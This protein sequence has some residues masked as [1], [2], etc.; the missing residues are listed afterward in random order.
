VTAEIDRWFAVVLGL[1]ALLHVAVVGYLHQV[2]WPRRPAL[3]EVPDRFIRQMSRA[4][5]PAPP[6]VVPAPVAAHETAAAPHRR[7]VPSA[8]PRPVH[9]SAERHADI[10]DQVRKMG[11]IPL[12]TAASAD[13]HAAVSDLLANGAVDRS[14]DEAMR[15][16]GGVTVASSDGL[17]GLAR[18]GSGTGRVGVPADLRGSG[19]IAEAGPND[20][21]AERDVVSHLKL[22]PPAVEGGHADLASITREI[23][24]RRKAI[25]ACYERALKQTPTLAGKLVVRFS[26]AAAGN[27]SAA[28]IDDDTL[29]APE[30]G[31]CVRA[32]VLRWR[33]APP[34]A[35]PVELSFPFVFQSGD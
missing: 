20:R 3:E 26:I 32:L 19:H 18:P 23:R 35:A 6:P 29:G 31:A 27:V 22:A 25:A 13:G 17:R 1:T 21:V 33:F 10:A 24:S 9:A 14:M 11:L 7:A 8:A 16:V 12:L 4:T 2:D 34:A 28:D 5:R 30:V 15:D